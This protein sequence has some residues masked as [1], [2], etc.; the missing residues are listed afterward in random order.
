MIVMKDLKQIISFVYDMRVRLSTMWIFALLNYLYADVLGLHDSAVLQGLL[1]GSVGGIVLNDSF[2]LASGVLMET[3]I[4]MVLL[5]RFLPRNANRWANAIVGLIHTAA[6]T[7]SL[8]AGEPKAY[9]IL[10]ATIEIAC[11][12]LIVWFAVRWPKHAAE[13][14]RVKIL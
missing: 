8:F 4:A 14:A 3:A 11:T 10:Y 13:I 2:L 7:A 1:S 6:V 9:Y 12:L 5:S